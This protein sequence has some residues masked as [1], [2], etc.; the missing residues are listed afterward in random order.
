M[1]GTA[2]G[3]VGFHLPDRPWLALSVGGLVILGLLWL[4]SGERTDL[5]R[6][7]SPAPSN[8]QAALRQAETAS[9][10][11]QKVVALAALAEVY[12]LAALHPGWEG[13]IA[14][15][16]AMQRLGWDRQVEYEGR[17]SFTARG[18]YLQAFH[19]ADA[20]G[21]WDGMLLAADR[22]EDLGDTS[23]AARLQALAWRKAKRDPQATILAALRMPEEEWP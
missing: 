17:L 12:R 15:G 21:D 4:G 13:M 19:Q 1:A 8:S 14:L 20:R 2:F 7:A 6:P 23:L 9:R 18:A 10:E 22:L 16:D 11:G 3:R 5:S